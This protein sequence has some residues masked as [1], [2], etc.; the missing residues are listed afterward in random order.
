MRKISPLRIGLFPFQMAWAFQWGWSELLIIWDDP[1]SVRIPY[2]KKKRH[3]EV[4]PPKVRWQAAKLDASSQ[5]LSHPNLFNNAINMVIRRSRGLRCGLVVSCL[6]VDIAC[7]LET[8]FWF[9]ENGKT[10]FYA[11]VEEV[12]QYVVWNKFFYVMDREYYLLDLSS[13][14]VLSGIYLFWIS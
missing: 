11:N 2:S 14:W 13:V 1:P 12:K 3:S 6:L 4:F 5:G 9:T 10:H 8:E 7:L